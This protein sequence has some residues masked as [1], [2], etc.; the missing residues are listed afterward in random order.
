MVVFAC[1]YISKCLLDGCNI[2]ILLMVTIRRIDAQETV[3]IRHSV[4]WPNHPVSHVLLDEDRTGYHYG[5]FTN[6]DI[7]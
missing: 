3:P 1:A 5:A 7:K 4:L 2:N 6:G